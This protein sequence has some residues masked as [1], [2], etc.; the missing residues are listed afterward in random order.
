M[1]NNIRVYELAR[2]LG[3]TNAQVI[4]LCGTLGI[5]VKGHSSGM[6]EPQ[7]D[8]VR[9]KAR[10]EGLATEVKKEKPAAK[11]PAARKA[12]RRKASG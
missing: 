7:A 10:R 11:K 5:G 3:M 4:D 8:R 1:A 6:P 9:R 12:S 2:E